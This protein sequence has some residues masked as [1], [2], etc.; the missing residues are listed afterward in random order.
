MSRF[1]EIQSRLESLSPIPVNMPKLY[2]LGDTGAGKTTIVRKI[3]GTEEFKFPSV[4]QKRTT[5]AVTEY[6]LSRD[7]PYKAT[8][9]FKTEGQILDLVSEILEIAT[10]N[11]YT[12]YRKNDLSAAAVAEDLEETPDEKFRLRYILT[13]EQLEELAKEI[14]QFMP[15]LDTEVKTLCSER[16]R[17]DEEF[18]DEEL[19]VV[20]D[21]AVDQHKEALA[22]IKTKIL[23][24]IQS[25]VAEVCDGHR[26][27]SNAD[28]FQHS[29]GDLEG[30]RSKLSVV[31]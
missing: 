12:R 11:A 6:V 8:Y 29:S 22:A 7:L 10:K 16:Q 31:T 1:E 9:L 20:V 25:K 4:Q 13:A 23:D 15:V 2:L 18:G 26:L 5:V 27:F 3:L 17:D 14:V 30:K 28:Y 21:I 19:G 24:H